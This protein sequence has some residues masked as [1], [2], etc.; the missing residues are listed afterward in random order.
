M[1]RAKTWLTDHMQIDVTSPISAPGCILAG[2][3]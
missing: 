1:R 3:M 2:A